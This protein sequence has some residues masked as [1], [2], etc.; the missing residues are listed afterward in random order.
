MATHTWEEKEK[1]D[2]SSF[3]VGIKISASTMEITVHNSQEPENLTT[4][5]SV[6]ATH[7]HI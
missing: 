5:P 4:I 1:G 3:M 2:H 7:A 6:Y